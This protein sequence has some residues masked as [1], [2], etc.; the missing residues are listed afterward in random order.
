M[1]YVPK[2]FTDQIIWIHSN[3]LFAPK[4]STIVCIHV[5][6]RNIP[7]QVTVVT[8]FSYFICFYWFLNVKDATLTRI[9][10][11]WTEVHDFS[12]LV[13]IMKVG[14]QY[15]KLSHF[16]HILSSHSILNDIYSNSPICE[17]LFIYAII[18][19]SYATYSN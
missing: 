2:S 8:A 5:F 10:E 6:I 3:S 9:Q 4:Y 15:A 12:K 14:F 16:T 1:V 19:N 18:Y 13:R 11:H 17:R 7:K